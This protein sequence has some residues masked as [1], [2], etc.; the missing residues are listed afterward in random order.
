MSHSA[1][2]DVATPGAELVGREVLDV[3]SETGAV[4]LAFVAKPEFAN[5]HGKVSGGFLAAM[6]DSAAA[7]PI[8]ASLAED[9]TIV[10][11]ELRVSYE[12]PAPLGPLFAVARIAERGDREIRSEGELSDP[13]GR[14]LARATATFRILQRRR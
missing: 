3:D 14:I 5:R 8:L 6:L 9:L 7:A 11:T 2:L 12:R 10:T 1:H 13:E 4:R